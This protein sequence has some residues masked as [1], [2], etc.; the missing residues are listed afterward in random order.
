M[1][2]CCIFRRHSMVQVGLFCFFFSQMSLT[3]K[4]INMQKELKW[5]FSLYSWMF[6]CAKVLHRTQGYWIP[7]RIAYAIYNGL[8]FSPPKTIALNYW[9]SPRW[10]ARK[11]LLSIIF[12]LQSKKGFYI[13]ASMH[14]HRSE[15]RLC[16][17]LILKNSWVSDDCQ[18]KVT[19]PWS[20]STFHSATGR[21]L[22]FNWIGLGS[23]KPWAF[24]YNHCMFKWGSHFQSHAHNTDT[25]T[26]DSALQCSHCWRILQLA[27]IGGML[28][29]C[30]ASVLWCHVTRLLSSICLE[31]KKK[32]K[33]EKPC[34]YS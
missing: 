21:V 30:C 6:T 18:R 16:S 14:C 31:K 20:W 8:L 15:C 3:Q 33:K 5:L 29:V 11:Q 17:M 13:N 4:V 1:F 7:L 23:D 19:R 27:I 25:F 2:A 10:F 12:A 9:Q 26:C 34:R 22:V 28:L 24:P 32:R